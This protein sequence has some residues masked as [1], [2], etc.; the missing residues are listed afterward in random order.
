MSRETPDYL[1]PLLRTAANRK[2]ISTAA[3]GVTL[4]HRHFAFIAAVIA[5]LE[6]VS[7]PDDVAQAFADA[8]TRTNPKFDRARFLAAC[9]V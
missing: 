9:G 5:Q 3:N 2:D 6:A 1:K 4:E 7:L 8:C